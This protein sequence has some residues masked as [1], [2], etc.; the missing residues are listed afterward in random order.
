MKIKI[1]GNDFS[2]ITV[3]W[4]DVTGDKKSP[5]FLG[6]NEICSTTLIRADNWSDAWDEFIDQSPTIDPTDVYMAY[7]FNSM[8]ELDHW[9]LHK[10]EDDHR[11]LVSGYEYQ[12]NFSGTGIVATYYL[13][14]IK[15]QF[16]AKENQHES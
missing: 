11:D 16:T 9:L 4:Y 7:G 1:R 5:V 6:G 2:I 14:L 10:A 3:D 15:F 12:S 8:E 13:W